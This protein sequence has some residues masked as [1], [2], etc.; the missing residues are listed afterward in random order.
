MVATRG[1]TA[2]S[3]FATS[4][5][6]LLVTDFMATASG[7]WPYADLKLYVDD[8]CIAARGFLAHV[9]VAAITR[10]AV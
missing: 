3:T 5:L 8:L 2:G 9:T 4:E 10:Y 6:R 7:Q 1:I